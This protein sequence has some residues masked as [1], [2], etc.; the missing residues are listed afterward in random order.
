M[1][2]LSTEKRKEIDAMIPHAAMKA[3]LYCRRQH[4]RGSSKPNWAGAFHDEM[5]RLCKEAGLRV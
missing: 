3:D 2:K 1:K 4:K 5:D